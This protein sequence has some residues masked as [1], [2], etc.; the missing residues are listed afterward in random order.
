MVLKSLSRHGVF[1]ATPIYPRPRWIT[2][3]RRG[4][5]CPFARFARSVRRE[6]WINE[7]RLAAAVIYGTE[8]ELLY[9]V[10][11]KSPGPLPT[12]SDHLSALFFVASVPSPRAVI[13]SYTKTDISRLITNISEAWKRR[14][15][16]IGCPPGTWFARPREEY[17]AG[18][19][20]GCK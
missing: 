19:N 11:P 6:R 7:R 4:F 16:F 8:T 13:S 5:S 10:R 1:G 9:S 3:Y 12:T 17:R 15:L 14:S 18:E 2:G 20:R